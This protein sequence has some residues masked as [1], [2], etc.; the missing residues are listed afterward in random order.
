MLAQLA[1]GLRASRGG[2]T[3]GEGGADEN[4]V[5]IILDENCTVWAL[6]DHLVA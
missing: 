2:G 1:A 4:G 5:S 6:T 3:A